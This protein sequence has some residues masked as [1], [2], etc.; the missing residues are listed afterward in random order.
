MFS[1]VKRGGRVY[2]KHLE[3]VNAGNLIAVLNDACAE[4]AHVMSDT[5]SLRGLG[6]TRKHSLVNHT[7]DEYVRYEEGICVTT[8]TVEVLLCESQ[9]ATSMACIIT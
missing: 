1:I 8:N 4:D 7:A 9:T 5:G 3:K 2:S 6:K